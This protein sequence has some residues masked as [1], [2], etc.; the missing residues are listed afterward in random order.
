[1]RGEHEHSL[2]VRTLE[3]KLWEISAGNSL[4]QA[5]RL[6]SLFSA[7]ETSSEWVEQQ[8]SWQHQH[9]TSTRHSDSEEDTGPHSLQQRH[10][11]M[12]LLGAV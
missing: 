9:G 2:T 12:T 7:A 1:M 6:P 4:Q 8:S 5:L 11:G 10:L 3:E